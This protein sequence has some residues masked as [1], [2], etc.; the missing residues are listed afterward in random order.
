MARWRQLKRKSIEMETKKLKLKTAF[1]TV[2]AAM[3][4]T[5]L[6]SSVA[7]AQRPN[8]SAQE[9]ENY[10]QRGPCRDPWVT[11]AIIQ[12]T[13]G[14]REPV[15]IGDLGECSPALYGGSWSNY[16]ELFIIVEQ[17]LDSMSKQKQQFKLLLDPNL[18]GTS[19]LALLE[20]G[21][22]QSQQTISNR[23]IGNDAGSFRT[24]ANRLVAA[25]GGNLVAAGA[26]N[27]IGM[28][29]ATLQGVAALARLPQFAISAGASYGVLSA[30]T[31]R[32]PKSTL[33]K[34]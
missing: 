29:G 7:S 18:A 23:L 31:V 3:I 17:T 30:D 15:G 5:V 34:K 22:V 16:N 12:A 13:A 14:T 8:P 32:L 20:N 33:K 25:G 24:L 4:A 11:F 6:F 19:Y 26:G 2:A 27:L 9:T 10:R 1:S 21:R 28:D